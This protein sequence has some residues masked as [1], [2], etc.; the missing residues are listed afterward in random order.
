MK[1]FSALELQR[2][3]GQV[4]EQALKEPVGITHHGRPR[5]VMMSMDEYRRLKRRDKRSFAVEELPEELVARIG[6]GEMDRRHD[7][8]DSLLD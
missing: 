3:V 8:L 1:T 7:H 5:I 6:A 2:N 4:Q